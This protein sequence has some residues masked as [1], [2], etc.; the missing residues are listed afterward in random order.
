M[1][2]SRVVV[3]RPADDWSA[4]MLNSSLCLSLLS[5]LLAA[6]SALA[7]AQP[8]I[9]GEA[10]EVKGLVTMSHGTTVG[11]VVDRTPLVDGARV[12]T[13]SSGSVTLKFERGCDVKL[14]PNQSVIVR[15]DETCEALIAAVQAIAPAP[16]AAFFA[17]P[18]GAAG[19][20]IGL[21]IVAAGG[22]DVGAGGNIPNLP[23]SGQ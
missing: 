8:E 1:A 14:K 15:R 20:L 2:Y 13:S 5:G 22:A 6:G 21:G 9:I 3:L 11:S 17:F 12:V 10:A 16:A 19:P 18:G 23:I 4:R 7:Q